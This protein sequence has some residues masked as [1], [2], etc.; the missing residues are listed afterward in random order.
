MKRKSL[1]YHKKCIK[2]LF[3]L[4]L[5]MTNFLNNKKIKIIRKLALIPICKKKTLVV[6][7][8]LQKKLM[9]NSLRKSSRMTMKFINLI[10]FC[11]Q[12]QAKK[13]L[14]FIKSTSSVLEEEITYNLGMNNQVKA[15]RVTPSAVIKIRMKRNKVRTKKNKVKQIMKRTKFNMLTTTKTKNWIMI[16]KMMTWTM[17][18]IMISMMMMMMISL[19]WQNNQV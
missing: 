10:H 8:L 2:N 7:I 16:C 18:Q 19:D 4:G 6:L 15:T 11:H 14:A 17:I 5:K 9:K 1:Q 13:P 12:R 3:Y